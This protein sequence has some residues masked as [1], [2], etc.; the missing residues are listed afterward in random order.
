MTDKEYSRFCM[1]V[2]E[3]A[4]DIGLKRT[5]S[6]YDYR[7]DIY[8]GTSEQVTE[9]CQCLHLRAHR[10]DRYSTTIIWVR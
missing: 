6:T 4:K 5:G 3:L 2:P 8:E 7:H 9:F 1:S 10:F